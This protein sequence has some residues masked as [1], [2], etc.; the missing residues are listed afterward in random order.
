M[1]AIRLGPGVARGV[2]LGSGIALL[3]GTGTAGWRAP[4]V[5]AAG[6]LLVGGLRRLVVLAR[7]EWRRDS[8]PGRAYL[9][10]VAPILSAL[11]LAAAAT[12]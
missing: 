1:T 3:A 8:P 11:L 9:G 10:A 2:L 12:S 7:L 4:V 6:G 5:G